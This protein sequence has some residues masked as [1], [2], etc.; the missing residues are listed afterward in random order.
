LHGDADDN[1]PVEQARTMI[2]ALEGHPN[3]QWHEQK[4][5]NHWWDA[6]P[7]PGADAVDWKPGFDLFRKTQLPEASITVDFLTPDPWIS[8]TCRW[9]RIGE[10]E[11]ALEASSVNLRMNYR[12]VVGTTQNV[13]SLAINLPILTGVTLDGQTIAVNGV[14]PYGFFKE[15]GKWRAV[16]LSSVVAVPRGAKSVFANHVCFVVGTAGSRDEQEATRELAQFWA[17]NYWYRGN[18]GVE[19]ITDRE[20]INRGL[21]AG[22]GNVVLFGNADNNRLWKLWGPKFGLQVNSG[23]LASEGHSASGPDFAATA[24]ADLGRGRVVLGVGGTGPNGIRLA[25][26]SPIFTSGAAYP[27]V[28]AW[29]PSMLTSGADGI[30]LAGFLSGPHTAADIVWRD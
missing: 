30:V 4:G 6:D 8:S 7:A 1:V 24:L 15:A 10:Q 19:V 28:L 29:N 5:A 13:L 22:G 25:A 2:K 3:L 9:A 23:R 18:A 20:A 14:G 17:E 12:E 26:R 21:A 11:K 27:D 16:P